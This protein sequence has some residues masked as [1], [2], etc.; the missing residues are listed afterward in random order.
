[1][2]LILK[3]WEQETTRRVL[4]KQARDMIFKVHAYF[5]R[6]ADNVAPIDSVAKCQE[7]TGNA[8]GVGL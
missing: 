6:E 7:R 8:R 5:K 2:F 4:H 1:M 3:M